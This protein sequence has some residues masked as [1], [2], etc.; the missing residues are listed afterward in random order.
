LGTGGIVIHFIATTMRGTISETN[1]KTEHHGG[2]KLQSTGWIIDARW[3]YA[4]LA[5]ILGLVA[6]VKFSAVNVF[7]ILTISL[8]IVLAA[9]AI[10]YVLL[11]K[12]RSTPSEPRDIDLLNISQI[13]LD[14]FYFFI[15]M[16]LTGGGVASIG[17]SF[18][19]MP[20]IVSMIIFGF[21]GSLMVAALSGLLVFISVFFHEGFTALLMS[22]D[23]TFRMTPELSSA[24]IQSGIIFM[25]YLLTGF[26]GGYISRM[27]RARDIL[28]LE[29]I[30]REASHVERLESLTKEFDKSAKLLV[31]R[32][33]ELT[34]A[35]DKLTQLDHMKSE[36]ISIVA[37]QLRTPLSAIKWTIKMLLDRDVGPINTEQ[38]ELL[39]KGFES[40]ERMILL[41]N[42]MLA[43]D[44]LESGK[45]KYTFVP[46]QFETLVEDMIKSLSTLAN[47][48]HV[49]IALAVPQQPL[50]KI[51]IDPDKMRD[52][53]QNLIDNAIKYT[54]EN[55]QVKVAVGVEGGDIHFSVKDNGIG[56][57]ADE[58]DKIFARFFRAK[59]A[60]HTV[61]EGSGL[62]LFIAQSVVKR[63]G[64]KIWFD[65]VENEGTTF[66][67]LLPLN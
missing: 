58:Q 48:K 37:H 11:K 33:L 40:N 20:I 63:H 15:V 27:M 54:K 19:F 9:N 35:N 17:H 3:Y 66:H 64:G 10:F 39:K 25:I 44:R 8:L 36:I 55:G 12:F 18:F 45:L 13:G 2:T 38:E 51:R 56:I 42:D 61:T 49:T 32:D 41:I 52:V 47:Q 22:P 46:V 24:L 14:L 4:P 30:T 43:V 16:F 53:L 26:F 6:H 1:M 50:E 7:V 67:V 23:S 34:S 5:Y 59:N 62:G 21:R 57:P 29:Q 28:L 31:R 65:S 60:T